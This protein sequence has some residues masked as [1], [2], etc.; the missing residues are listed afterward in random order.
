MRHLRVF[1]CGLVSLAV[2]AGSALGQEAPARAD[3]PLKGPTV[4]ENRAPHVTDQMSGGPQGRE[5]RMGPQIPMRAYS[6]VIGKLRGENAPAELRL[7][8]DQEDK[9]A[10][11]E[12][13]YREAARTLGQEMRSGNNAPRRGGEGEGQSRRERAQEAAKNGPKPSDYQTR[14]WAVLNPKQQAHVKD[15][16]DQIRQD[17]Q[18][19]RSEE[20][21]QRKLADK[22]PGEAGQPGR[23]AP[24]AQEE[25]RPLR[26]RGMRLMRRISQLPE[27]ERNQLLKRLEDELDRRGVPDAPLDAPK[28]DKPAE[29]K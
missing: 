18:K 15:E 23:P 9:L 4:K 7:S 19:R 26:E 20:A 5:G 6:E 3:Q 13:E 22:K 28:S 1:G 10:V 17:L 24:A 29:R 8:S 2:V 14:I 16:L 27:A 21:M 11:I 25:G 12:K